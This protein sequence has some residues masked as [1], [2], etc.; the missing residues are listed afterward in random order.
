MARYS[1]IVG[2]TKGQLETSPG[3]WEEAYDERAMTGNITRQSFNAQN[4]EVINTGVILSNTISVVGDT[5]SF[6]NYSNIRYV[7]YLGKKWRVTSVEVVRP[8]IIIQLGT[9]YNE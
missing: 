7:K 6:E 3:V 5:Y 1:G 9:L 4:G 2:F 8:R